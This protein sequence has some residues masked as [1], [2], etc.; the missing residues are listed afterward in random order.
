[1]GAAPT[2]ILSGVSTGQR[3]AGGALAQSATATG[4]VGGRLGREAKLLSFAGSLRAVLAQSTNVAAVASAPALDPSAGTAEGTPPSIPPSEPA[5]GVQ[6]VAM[7]QIVGAAPDSGPAVAMGVG[8]LRTIAVSAGPTAA[9][10][11]PDQQDVPPATVGIP[12]GQAFPP[13]YWPETAGPPPSP[14]PGSVT[15]GANAAAT[16][17]LEPALDRTMP[18]TAALHGQPAGARADE[19]APLTPPIQGPAS[20]PPAPNAAGDAAP[21]DIA[22]LADMAGPPANSVTA[23]GNGAHAAATTRLEPASDRPLP[24]TAAL[25]GHTAGARAD[26]TAPATP[27]VQSPASNLAAPNAAAGAAPSDIAALVAMAGSPAGFARVGPQTT[28]DP[29]PAN[30]QTATPVR[31]IAPALL[32]LGGTG[33]GTQ[34]LTLRLD[35]ANLGQVEIRVDRPKFGPPEVRIAVERSETLALLQHDRHQLQQALDQ[36]GIPSEGRQIEFR[37]VARIDPG[38][39]GAPAP[40]WTAGNPNGGQGGDSAAGHGS[41]PGDRPGGRGQSGHADSSDDARSSDGAGTA[42]APGWLRVG[43]NITA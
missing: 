16:A 1:M 22:A 14:P 26:E 23:D 25:H 7:P 15:A 28:V 13:A 2:A 19:T 20:G 33:A 21:A 24:Q 5:A 32:S 34:H 31:Q 40:S 42:Y 12:S 35:P 11:G 41:G 6:S 10:T 29:L 43:V 18:Q 37:L 3:E 4:T 17:R 36:A 39:D 30:S 8:K 9:A 27:Q 38:G